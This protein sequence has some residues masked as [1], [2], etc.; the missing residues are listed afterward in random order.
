MLNHAPNQRYAHETRGHFLFNWHKPDH[1]IGTKLF[2][3]LNLVLRPFS[4]VFG[5]KIITNT[6]SEWPFVF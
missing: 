3:K 4:N 5:N 1:G 6:F 2:L